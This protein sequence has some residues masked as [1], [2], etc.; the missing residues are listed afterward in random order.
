MRAISVLEL[1]TIKKRTLRA[2]VRKHVK[3]K[4]TTTSK[5]ADSLLTPDSF[6]SKAQT[7][8]TQQEAGT[9]ADSAEVAQKGREPTAG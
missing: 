9:H 4:Q 5:T 7:T 3:P 6:A 2:Y 1:V 8:R